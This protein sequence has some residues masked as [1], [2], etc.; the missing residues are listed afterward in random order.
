[1][2]VEG[3]SDMT[4]K[5]QVIGPRSF[6]TRRLARR[7]AEAAEE[8]G[9]DYELERL[10]DIDTMIRLGVQQAPALAIDGTVLISGHVPSIRELTSLLG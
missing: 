3:A 6:A 5:L 7:A 4:M 1:V 8:L 10:E 2:T 9:L